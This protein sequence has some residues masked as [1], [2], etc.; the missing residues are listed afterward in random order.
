MRV[1]FDGTLDSEPFIP[2]SS[3]RTGTLP[4]AVGT[5]TVAVQYRN[6]ALMDS[7]VFTD[8]IVLDRRPNLIVTGISR[9]PTTVRRGN[10]FNVADIT[11][12]SGATAVG[13][14]T[15]TR[16]YLSIDK[17]RST[18]DILLTGARTVPNLAANT[19]S[20]GSR[21]VGVPASSATGQYWLIACADVGNLVAEFSETDNC[22]ASISKVQ[23][24]T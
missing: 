5:K 8:T 13:R 12:N 4:G 2:Y 3:T 7:P 19:E 17:V 18:N 24:T 15:S 20:T 9:P 6:N 22:R 21:S 10:S 14:T 11:R 16:Y 1:A 23:V